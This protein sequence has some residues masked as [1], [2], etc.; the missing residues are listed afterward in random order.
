MIPFSGYQ[1]DQSFDNSPSKDGHEAQ[2]IP[3]AFGLPQNQGVSAF[4]ANI[5]QS[6]NQQTEFQSPTFKNS[7]GDMT[8]NFNLLFSSVKNSRNFNQ[9]NN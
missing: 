6:L 7:K 1:Q 4:G 5:K 9:S 8:D 2:L 3:L